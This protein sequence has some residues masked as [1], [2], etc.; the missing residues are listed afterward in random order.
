MQSSDFVESGLVFSLTNKQSLSKF[1]YSVSDFQ[2]HGD[3]FKF[4][5]THFDTYGEFPSVGTLCENYPTLDPS[6]QSLNLDYA[7][8]VFQKQILFRQI[9]GAF[10]ENKDLIGVEPKQALSKIMTKLSDIE[11]VYDEDVTEYNS[12]PENRLDSWKTRKQLRRQNGGMIGV[13]TSFPSINRLGVGW[14]PG[15][16]ISLYARPTVGKTWVCIHAAATAVMQGIRTLLISTE[17]P[18]EA[19]SMRTDVVLAKMMGYD[20][21]HQAI[22]N[23]DD[24]NEEEYRT[25]L[26]ALE[27][28]QLLVCD[29]IEGASGITIDSI[30]SL[31]RKYNP[32]FVVLDG[33]YLISTGISNRKAMWEQSH[34]VF[35]GMKNLCLSTN[36]PIFVSTQ[37]T[38]DAGAN[39]FVPPRPD[40]VAFGDALIRASDVAMAMA[41]V[42]GE[43]DKRVIQYQKYRDGQLDTDATMLKWDVNRG[44][45]AEIPYE[46]QEF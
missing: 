39:M 34:A 10:Q 1:K 18:T 45:I 11:I 29:H 23:G 43:P 46:E 3:A 9:V 17:M 27:E 16:L 40:Q 32:E 31:I 4:V 37:A 41:M 28:N 21:S 12:K 14:M 5:T 13:P 24:L 20:L 26:Q 36:T 22:R 2:K 42:E 30:A 6:A 38:R 8:D 7:L 19:I 44:D 25:F 33:I 35:Y 15:E